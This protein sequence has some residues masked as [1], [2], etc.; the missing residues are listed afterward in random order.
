MNR[1]GGVGSLDAM[2]TRLKRPFICIIAGPPE[3][4]KWCYG[5][6]QLMYAMLMETPPH[7]EFVEELT[8]PV[9]FNEKQGTWWSSTT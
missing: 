3:K 2:D 6:W 5:E 8:D 9:S 1:L 7:M 4:L